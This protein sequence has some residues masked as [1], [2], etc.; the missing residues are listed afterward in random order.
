MNPLNLSVDPRSRQYTLMHSN[1]PPEDFERPSIRA[2]ISHA[3]ERIASLDEEISALQRKLKELEEERVLVADY[4]T[5]NKAILSPLRRMPAEVLTEIFS[6]LR[7]Y[8]EPVFEGRQ[9]YLAH[10]PWLPS[11]VSRRWR[12]ISLS[13][14]S[15]WSHI[16]IDYAR[17]YYPAS[18]LQLE[19]HIQR[20]K[21]L[22]LKILFYGAEDADSDSQ[23]QMLDHLLEYS[24]RWEDLL[25][26]F[27]PQLV[28]LLDTRSAQIKASSLKKLRVEW[29]GFDSQEGVISLD[30]FSSIASLTHVVLQTHGV[31]QNPGPEH[32]F[33][34]ISFP[35]HLTHYEVNCPWH[36]HADI[37]KLTPF[38]VKARIFVESVDDP[39]PESMVALEQLGWLFTTSPKIL[40]RI[41]APRLNG[42]AFYVAEDLTDASVL[43]SVGALIQHS[44]CVLTQLCFNGLPKEV[45]TTTQILQNLPS[46]ADLRIIC[47]LPNT[48]AVERLGAL[49]FSLTIFEAN[50]L[51]TAAPQ[52]RTFSVAHV[53]HT[54]TIPY[55]KY[56]D[57]LNS[58][59]EAADCELTAATLAISNAPY[60]DSASLST[61]TAIRRQ[62]HNFTF[63]KEWDAHKEMSFW[64]YKSTWPVYLD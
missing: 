37:L 57:M 50:G 64:E 55:Q 19:A 41:H 24:S 58:R 17:Q 27:S 36:M 8:R 46:L 7:P 62:G 59:L 14:P 42:L 1:D 34:P 30:A 48:I 29:H 32:R 6:H 49:I 56:A 44:A 10:G 26:V 9:S 39:L 11:H 43:A 12:A 15:L 40:Q 31:T 28:S 61:L 47:D 23:M 63:L 22:S 20:A 33:I 13:T 21:S 60:P 4:Q 2:A 25:V 51:N 35:T 3:D 5:K 38:V 54:P 52:L 45:S 16:V 53:K 18:P